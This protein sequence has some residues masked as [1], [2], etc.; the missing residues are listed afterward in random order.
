MPDDIVLQWKVLIV[1]DDRDNLMLAA[2]YL[3]YLGATVHTATDGVSGMEALKEF[4]PTI[5]LMD[6]SMPMM[7]GWAMIGEVRKIE[8]LKNIPV[9]ALTA[10]AMPEV[11]G[12]VKEAGFTG[13][14]TKPF[15]FSRLLRELKHWVAEREKPAAEKA[16]SE[17]ERAGDPPGGGE[18]IEKEAPQ[19]PTAE[20][21]APPV[22]SHPESGITNG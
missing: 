17:A 14:V 8:A 6:L 15:V 20:I 10:H 3:T 7:D 18:V 4:E 11:E 16:R 22:K 12:Q 2:E 19:P 13:Y 5:I 9:I 1:D 21:A